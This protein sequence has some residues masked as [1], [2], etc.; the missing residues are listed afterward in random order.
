MTV[1]MTCKHCRI[2]VEANT[3]VELVTRV[4]AH[5]RG[6]ERPHDLTREHILKRLEHQTDQHSRQVGEPSTIA[7]NSSRATDIAATPEMMLRPVVDDAP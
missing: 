6:H 2:T 3:D 1:S 5:A 4:Q 7:Q